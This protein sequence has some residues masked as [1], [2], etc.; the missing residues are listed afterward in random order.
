MQRY[1]RGGCR[2][3]TFGLTASLL[4]AA[5]GG[6]GSG[7]RNNAE[8]EPEPTPVP[9]GLSI[10]GR[11][12]V[13]DIAVVDSDTADTDREQ[14]SNDAVPQV[15]EGSRAT[16]S[17]FVRFTEDLDDPQADL[18]DNY[19]VT[20]EPG[21]VVNLFIAGDGQ[22][23]D[24]DLFL[25]E[26]DAEIGDFASVSVALGKF[27]TVIAPEDAQGPQQYRVQVFAF[28]GSSN[29]VLTTGPDTVG[30]VEPT[31]L[32]AGQD[33]AFVPGQLIVQMKDAPADGIAAK[34]QARSLG[35]NS[36]ASVPGGPQLLDV[37]VRPKSASHA[38]LTGASNSDKALALATLYDL[39]TLQRNP[40]VEYA[41]L[42]RI[43]RPLRVPDDPLFAQQAWHYNLINLPQAWDLTQG[44]EDVLVA[45]L[46]SGILTEHPDL[47]PNLDPN[48]PDGYDFIQNPVLAGDDDGPDGDAS[49]PFA[50]SHGTHV[51]G[52]IS[53]ATNNGV[54]VAGVGW[55]TRIM[56][57]RV[58]GPGFDV[59]TLFDVFNG[60]L[61]AA[62]LPNSSGALPARAADIANLS[63][64]LASDLTSIGADLQPDRQGRTLSPSFFEIDILHRV[65][66][67]GLIVI[68]AAGNNGDRY[69]FFP[70]SYDGV[71][72]VGAVDPASTRSAYSTF[73]SAVDV[74]APGGGTLGTPE[75]QVIST[76][77]QARDDGSLSA[78]YQGKVG[79]S[80]AAPHVAG[81]VAL[82][83]AVHP[84][85][86]PE[87]LDQVLASGAITRDLGAPGKDWE[88]GH[89]LIDAHLAVMEAQRLADGGVPGPA[90]QTPNLAVVFPYPQ[91]IDGNDFERGP[92][93]TLLF[94]P[95]FRQTSEDGEITDATIGF[96][97]VNGGTGTLG[98]VSVSSDVPWATISLMDTDGDGITRGSVSL[99]ESDFVTGGG[100]PEL[101]EVFAITVQAGDDV[102]ETLVS[103]IGTTPTEVE[104]ETSP[105]D[106][107]QLRMRLL[108]STQQTVREILVS[109]NPEGFYDFA[110]DDLAPGEYGL[111]AGT[112]ND[113]DGRLCDA[114]EACA[115]FPLPDSPGVINVRDR[116][117]RDL[118]FRLGFNASVSAD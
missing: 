83:K 114:G 105:A 90:L 17:G 18:F 16:V 99:S 63:L 13:P 2:A 84:G 85:L 117:Q 14:I 54:G 38:A 92:R 113:G 70:A 65:R 91:S 6:S 102:V 39:K 56:P 95:G 112:D 68:A 66:E 36:L 118:L 43:M 97:V 35:A 55:N 57:I 12:L 29:Y 40:D 69:A 62:G 42:N 98:E 34:A 51:A 15:I 78:V 108:D 86:T 104:D 5:C 116:S 88:Y 115:V 47:A 72:S 94:A 73:N 107:G 96:T 24:L 19:L 11:M 32:A 41:Q 109:P 64:G 33:L 22:D 101:G 71:I 80:M 27:E 93:P 3:V 82:M 52:T 110:F 45:V 106:L 26:E 76:D 44:S 20:L 100:D 77:S 60:L 23:N 67:A 111:L 28:S 49:D 103:V 1:G 46:D 21:Q 75:D 48:D 87:M 25:Y 30:F 50:P 53:A 58:I 9:Q 59:A 10:S 31:P 8:P 7:N 79:T 74:S 81:V 89:G 37:S 4:L 61:Y